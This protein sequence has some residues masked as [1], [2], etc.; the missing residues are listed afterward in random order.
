[1]SVLGIT[2]IRDTGLLHESLSFQGH[3]LD[4]CDSQCWNSIRII[5]KIKKTCRCLGFIPD[6]LNV[7]L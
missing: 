3:R 7:D 5:W 4:Q 1:M 6:Q 2:A